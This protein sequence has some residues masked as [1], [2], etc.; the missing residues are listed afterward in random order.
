MY[1]HR[2]TRPLVKRY[3]SEL[4]MS[5]KSE[6]K[7]IDEIGLTFREHILLLSKELT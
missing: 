1:G 4:T 7:H 2:N 3:N 6:I 5:S